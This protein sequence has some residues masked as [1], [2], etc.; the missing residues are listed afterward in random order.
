MLVTTVGKSG[1]AF[2]EKAVGNSE[3]TTPAA[4]AAGVRAT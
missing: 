4:G 3:N 2:D 1:M